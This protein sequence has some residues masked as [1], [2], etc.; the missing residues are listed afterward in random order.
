MRNTIKN[1]N[2]RFITEKWKET[3]KEKNKGEN[4]KENIM[5]G[6]DRIKK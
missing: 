4:K 1:T 5:A 6:K 3:K 2:I